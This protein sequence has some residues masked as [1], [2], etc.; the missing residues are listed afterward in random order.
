MPNNP[1]STKPH[2]IIKMCNQSNHA[3]CLRLRDVRLLRSL[4]DQEKM[5]AEVELQ[6]LSRRLSK[7]FKKIEEVAEKAEEE[8]DEE[9]E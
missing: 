9:D 4:P 6:K 8:S 3:N 7:A 5:K 1:K 2:R